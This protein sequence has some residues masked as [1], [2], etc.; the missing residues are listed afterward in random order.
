MGQNSALLTWSEREF[1]SLYA[2]NSKKLTTLPADDI[3]ELMVV[4]RAKVVLPYDPMED[5]EPFVPPEHRVALP[6]RR[7]RK[8]LFWDLSKADKR[9]ILTAGTVLLLGIG[10]ALYQGQETADWRET[11]RWLGGMVVGLGAFN[12]V[13]AIEDEL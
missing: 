10:V 6:P 13:G 2:A 11:L 12:D 7:P 8:R 3:A 1:T 5:M 9:T 4:D